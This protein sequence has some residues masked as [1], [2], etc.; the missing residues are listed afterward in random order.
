[1]RE[2][3]PQSWGFAMKGRRLQVLVELEKGPATSRDVADATGI[4]FPNVAA[5]LSYLYH[6][7]VAE[8]SELPKDGRGPPERV[9]RLAA[10]DQ[11]PTT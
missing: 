1:M 7:G 9:Y 2:V 8:R 4:P 11:E 5:T 6:Q 3:L 10:Q